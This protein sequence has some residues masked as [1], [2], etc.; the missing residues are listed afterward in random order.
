MNAP[1]DPPPRHP[2][3]PPASLS[4]RRR[5]R[6]PRAAPPL[7][8]SRGLPPRDDRRSLRPSRADA[9]PPQSQSYGSPTPTQERGYYQPLDQPLDACG[10]RVRHNLRKRGSSS[11]RLNG[12]S[13][14]NSGNG[15]YGIGIGKGKGNGNGSYDNGDY[16][17]GTGNG[18]GARENWAPQRARRPAPKVASISPARLSHIFTLVIVS[19]LIIWGSVWGLEF[20]VSLVGNVVRLA[21]GRRDLPDDSQPPYSERPDEAGAFEP[22]ASGAGLRGSSD[23][24]DEP[25]GENTAPESASIHDLNARSHLLKAEGRQLINED[26][27]ASEADEEGEGDKSYM[28]ADSTG[29]F[30]YAGS[31]IETTRF[32]NSKGRIEKNSHPAR[33]Y[34]LL[35]VALGAATSVW[36]RLSPPTEEKGGGR[37]RDGFAE[38]DGRRPRVVF[39]TRAEGGSGCTSDALG[40]ASEAVGIVLYAQPHYGDAG[41]SDGGGSAAYRMV[42]EYAREGSS[43]CR[44]LAGKASEDATLVRE[45]EWHHVALFVTE[46][47]TEAERTSLYVDGEVAARETLFRDGRRRLPSA[48]SSRTVVGRLALRDRDGSESSSPAGESFDLDGRVGMLA[49]WQTQSDGPDD[50]KHMALRSEEDEDHVVNAV[51]GA[52]FDVRAVRELSLRGLAVREPDLLYTF[53]GQGGDKAIGDLYLDAPRSVHEAVTGRNG[54]VVSILEEDGMPSHQRRAFVPLGG[55]RYRE[56]KDGTYVPPRLDPSERRELAEVARARAEVVRGAMRHVWGGYRKYAFGK[57]ELLPLSKRGQDNWGG[58]GT[59]LVDSLST[60][61]L[62]DMKEEFWEARNWVRDHLDFSKV[63]GGVSVFETTIRNLG[64]LLSAHDLSGDEAFLEK[65]DDLGRRLMRAF[66]GRTGVPYGE[67]ELF[68]GGRSYNTGWHSSDAV[69]SEIGKISTLQLEFRYLAKATGRSEYATDVMRALDEVLKLDA[70]SGLYPTFIQNT[71]QQLSFGN[72]DISLGAMGDSFYEYLLK[73]WL[74]GG[75][76][77]TKYRRLYDKSVSGIMDK[78]IHM[79]RPSYLTYVAELKNGRVIHKMDHLSCFLG[80]NLALGAYTHPDGLESVNAQRQ[81]RTGKQLAY[82]CYQ[83]YASSKSGLSPEFV[84]FG[85]SKDDF[86]KGNSPYYILRP[87]ASETFF[88]LYHLTKDPVYREWGWEVFQA[89]EEHCKTD[90][91][92]ASIRNVDTI[93]KNDRMESFFLA[94]TL[95]Y[96]FLLQDDSHDIDL[97]NKASE[98]SVR[99]CGNHNMPL[100]WNF[101]FVTVSLIFAACVQYRGASYADI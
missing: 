7:S 85:S 28:G 40:E 1:S 88:I 50:P 2:R 27:P 30:F 10:G 42:L 4:Q 53:D 15:S 54:T 23:L 37:K 41:S 12:S 60:L 68:E 67:V 6:D 32:V 84:K 22:L 18:Q 19:G 35:P 3:D 13:P 75:K 33:T 36:I 49:F 93:E 5:K 14:Y 64:G 16:G 76:R 26:R 72:N 91:G 58:M 48:P 21:F 52:G 94:E 45:G 39:S 61:W 25:E 65:A 20:G 100:R 63:Q 74:Q 51:R 59:T 69:L 78:L 86:S 81:L 99:L 80:G 29:D 73:I 70:E 82:T 55:N 11:D 66:D 89:I 56:Y 96:L 98:M 17:N 77:E 9:A 71:R 38:E 95:K 47:G 83:M 46:A 62:M 90:V 44:T 101:C 79:S 31:T 92:Y 97:L 87:E 8:P 34:A 57:D 24:S 43:R